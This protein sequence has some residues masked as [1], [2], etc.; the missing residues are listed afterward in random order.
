MQKLWERKKFTDM[1]G[2]DHSQNVRLSEL[3]L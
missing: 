3:S 2:T 1:Q